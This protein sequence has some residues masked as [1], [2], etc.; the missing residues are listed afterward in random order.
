MTTEIKFNPSLSAAVA[1]AG[2]EANEQPG[3]LQEKQVAPLLGGENV[4]VSSGSMTDLE[5]LVARIKI[6][7]DKTR[8]GVAQMRLA[9]VTAALDMA[10]VRLSEAQAAAFA[11][12]TEQQD[13][14][15]AYESELAGLYAEYGIGPNDNASAVMEAKIEALEKAIERAVQE[16]KDH[17]ETVEKE[18][19]KLERELAK[20]KADAARIPVLQTGITNASAKIS[21]SMSILGS[22]QMSAIAMAL[23]KVAE[24][25][26][27]PEEPISAVDQDKEEKKEIALNPFV[28]IQESLQKI[29]EAILRTIDENRQ[30]NV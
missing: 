12:L 13:L 3:V 4:R 8:T 7:D 25:T 23:S 15:V 27:T 20:A 24:G 26:E 28:A 17:N 10:G 1:A 2:T 5:K 6:E 9:A 19:E 11:T 30:L 16:G 18:K 14:K 21:E 29:D 22:N